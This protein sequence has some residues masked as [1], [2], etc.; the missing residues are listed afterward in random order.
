[1]TKPAVPGAVKTRLMSKLDPHTAAA[2]HGAMVECVLRRTPCYVPARTAASYLVAIDE[3]L[4]PTCRPDALAMTL[5]PPW[6]RIDQGRGDLGQRLAHAWQRVGGGPVVFLGGDSPDIPTGLLESIL[7][8]LDRSDIVLGPAG[9][10]GY[11]TLA[12]RAFEPGLLNGID[13][14]TAC[15]YDQ[16]V[17]AARRA[18]LNTVSLPLWHDVDRPQDL[19]A[20]RNRLRR[21][22]EVALVCLRS[23]LDRLLLDTEL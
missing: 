14:G 23:K 7:P 10:G 16:T 21:T 2:V 20:L 5:P 8:A 9:D 1:M 12:C 18:N 15:V 6:H 22:E 3:S 11:W 4:V 19:T 13:W 17:E